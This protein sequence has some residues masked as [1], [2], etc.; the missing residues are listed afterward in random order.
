MALLLVENELSYVELMVMFTPQTNK[1]AASVHNLKI[2]LM[3]E[4]QDPF[5]ILKEEI[6]SK[7][8]SRKVKSLQASLDGAVSELRGDLEYKQKELSEVSAN[9]ARSVFRTRK[10]VT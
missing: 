9:G 10:T 6:P 4:L 7:E 2:R 1:K 8:I 3:K 5:T